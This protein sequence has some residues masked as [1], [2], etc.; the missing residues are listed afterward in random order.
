MRQ[1]L[2]HGSQVLDQEAMR[3]ILVHGGKEAKFGTA[4]EDRGVPRTRGKIKRDFRRALM[5]AHGCD[6]G[7]PFLSHTK[8]SRFVSRVRGVPGPMCL[9]STSRANG[10]DDGRGFS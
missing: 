2:V 5:L 10:L 8:S 3:Q 1:I 9:S 6:F 7:H 4:A